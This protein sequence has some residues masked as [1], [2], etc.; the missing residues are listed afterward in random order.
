M[1]VGNDKAL[2]IS[3]FFVA[4]SG[5]QLKHALQKML[6]NFKKINK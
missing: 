2:T 4:L 5:V 3:T 1:S 6:Q